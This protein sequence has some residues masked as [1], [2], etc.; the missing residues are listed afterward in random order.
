MTDCTSRCCAIVDC[1]SAISSI[2]FSA[3]LGGVSIA[4]TAM[5]DFSYNLP[6]LVKFVLVM[7]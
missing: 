2:D 1:S 4:A 3:V 7:L 5:L 6:D